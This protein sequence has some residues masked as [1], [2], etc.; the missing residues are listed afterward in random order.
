MKSRLAYSKIVLE[1]HISQA[2]LNSLGTESWVYMHEFLGVVQH[3][4]YL[5]KLE[6]AIGSALWGEGRGYLKNC[7]TTCSPYSLCLLVK[8]AL[9]CM[10]VSGKEA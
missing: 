7:Y 8:T 5:M 4:L 9:H 2:L 3:N 10:F 6:V 1:K